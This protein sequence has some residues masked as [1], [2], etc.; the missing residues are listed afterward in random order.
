MKI[1]DNHTI[2]SDF[3]GARLA[4]ALQ[5]VAEIE[6]WAWRIRKCPLAVVIIA[7][8]FLFLVLGLANAFAQ[9]QQRPLDE[10]DNPELIGKRDIN[11]GQIDFYSLD[12]ETALGRQLVIA[13]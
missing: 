3:E 4:Q 2:E 9:T 11:K 1:I 8:A 5:T 12:K 10:K 13:Y 6:R 7:W